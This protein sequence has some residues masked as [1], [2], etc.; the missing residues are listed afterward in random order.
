MI[1]FIDFRYGTLIV[2]GGVGPLTLPVG[3]IIYRTGPLPLV[4]VIARC[5]V[6]I[7]VVPVG[8]E[9]LRC[10]YLRCCGCYPQPRCC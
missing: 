6:T 8:G 9:P 2:G 4:V 10:C 1:P 5:Y 7:Y 3:G